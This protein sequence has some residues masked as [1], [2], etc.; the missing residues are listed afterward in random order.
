[1]WTWRDSDKS[2]QL[3]SRLPVVS[4]ICCRLLTM[5][6]PRRQVTTR[7]LTGVWGADTE[8][9]GNNGTEQEME[10]TETG[11]GGAANNRKPWAG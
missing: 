7:V 3:V 8:R 1:M 5:N 11:A 6:P 4:A 9:D 10:T 2:E